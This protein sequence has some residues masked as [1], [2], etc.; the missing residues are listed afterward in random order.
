MK[1]IDG[2]KEKKYMKKIDRWLDGWM[3]RK[4]NYI[5]IWLVGRIKKMKKID[6]WLDEQKKYI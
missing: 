4:K 1:K 2:W 3:D 5:Y 6:G